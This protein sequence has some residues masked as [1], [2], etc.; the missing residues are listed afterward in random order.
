MG[1]IIL[2]IFCGKNICVRKIYYSI[3]LNILLKQNVLLLGV[4]VQDNL[5]LGEGR[6]LD[7]LALIYF[8][9]V[10]MVSFLIFFVEIELDLELENFYFY[11]WIIN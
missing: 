9:L 4:I 6:V 7:C 11:I 10:G 3:L 2:I 8:Y 1:K 5:Y